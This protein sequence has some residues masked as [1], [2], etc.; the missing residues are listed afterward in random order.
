[1]NKEI[2]T[3]ESEKEERALIRKIYGLVYP[4]G[5]SSS[6]WKD[7]LP[8]GDPL[9]IFYDSF[10]KLDGV[11]DYADL[12]FRCLLK[13]ICSSSM[14]T[15]VDRIGSLLDATW[16]NEDPI[17]TIALIKTIFDMRCRESLAVIFY[18]GRAEIKAVY[19]SM[20]WD[21]FCCDSD[22]ERLKGYI[23]RNA[24]CNFVMIHS[25]PGRSLAVSEDDIRFTESIIEYAEILGSRLTEHFIIPCFGDSDDFIGVLGEMGKR[26]LL[27]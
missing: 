16:E 2:L 14:L 18:T 26:R 19:E 11:S 6:D 27:D 5:K 23:R 15:Y 20:S 1:M 22:N 17:P 8:S 21:M 3:P 25:H 24:P 10:S 9:E 7:A 13:L 4:D 12:R